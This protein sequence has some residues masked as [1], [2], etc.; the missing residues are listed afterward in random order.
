MRRSSTTSFKRKLA[1]E[2][3]GADLSSYERPLCLGGPGDKRIKD[4][5]VDASAVSA[6]NEGSADASA[7]GSK[8]PH[9]AKSRKKQDDE[10]T[11]QVF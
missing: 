7:Q 1:W 6:N 8:A 3:K 10:E 9:P 2:E 4:F 5:S 11:G